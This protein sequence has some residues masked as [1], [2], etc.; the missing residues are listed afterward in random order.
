MNHARLATLVNIKSML[1]VRNKTLP[2]PTV[3][4]NSGIQIHGGIVF[5]FF[6]VVPNGVQGV[7]M[8]DAHSTRSTFVIPVRYPIFVRNDGILAI[9]VENNSFYNIVRIE[10]IQALEGNQYN[11]FKTILINHGAINL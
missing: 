2:N 10:P 6:T 11:G 4:N 1:G 7:P 5:K 9:L 3:L 8:M